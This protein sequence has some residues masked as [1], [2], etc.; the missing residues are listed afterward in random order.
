MRCAISSG[1]K[2]I[3][4]IF[5]IIIIF[6]NIII[7]I[8]IFINIIIIII[9]ILLIIEI[10]DLLLF[11]NVF[12]CSRRHCSRCFCC[13]L[14]RRSLFR[15]GFILL[16]FCCFCYYFI[17]HPHGDF[18]MTTTNLLQAQNL[19]PTKRLRLLT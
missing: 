16:L 13:R 19:L 5:I 14:R 17:S 2:I 10:D 12:V 6:I 1:Y 4:L 8:I 11:V 9:I 15:C 3:F 18:S 7:I